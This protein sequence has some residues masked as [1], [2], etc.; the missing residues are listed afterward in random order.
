MQGM[1]RREGDEG[2]V[3]GRECGVRGMRGGCERNERG[4]G[5]EVS[6]CHGRIM[7]RQ[8]SAASAK[9]FNLEAGWLILVYSVEK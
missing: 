3:Y 8:Q 2:D 1:E 7:C 9:K 4:A 5:C 6:K